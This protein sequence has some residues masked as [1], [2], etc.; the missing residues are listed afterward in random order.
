MYKAK[1][2]PTIFRFAQEFQGQR[3]HIVEDFGCNRT[4]PIALCGRNCNKRG[5]W[6]LTCNFPLGSGC[7]TC[8]YSKYQPIME[9][10]G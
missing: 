3:L 9:A 2:S 1:L 10:K 7:I 5:A 6:R 8:R 4:A